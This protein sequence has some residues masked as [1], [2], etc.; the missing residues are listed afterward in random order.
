MDQICGSLSESRAVTS[1]QRLTKP[2][3]HTPARRATETHCGPVSVC[4]PSPET[5]PFPSQPNRHS[6]SAFMKAVFV[7]LGKLCALLMVFFF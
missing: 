2:D 6:D 5:Q 7:R 4:A 3:V 1:R